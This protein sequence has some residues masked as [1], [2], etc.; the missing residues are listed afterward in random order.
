MEHACIDASAPRFHG[1]SKPCAKQ[2]E[3]S[4][5]CFGNGGGAAALHVNGGTLPTVGEEE[6]KEKS[7]GERMRERK[8]E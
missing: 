6:M 5:W 4:P 1:V 7:M 8:K 3:P 2:V